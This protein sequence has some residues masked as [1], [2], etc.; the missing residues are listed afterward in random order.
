MSG[1]V[2]KHCMQLRY[3]SAMNDRKYRKKRKKNTKKKGKERERGMGTSCLCDSQY[4]CL[5]RVTSFAL[6]HTIQSVYAWY[7][8]NMEW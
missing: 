1:W 6:Q 2:Q 4:I 3:R 8:M 7:I 5:R